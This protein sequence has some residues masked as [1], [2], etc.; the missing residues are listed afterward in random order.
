M[1]KKMTQKPNKKQP[2]P[3]DDVLKQDE[4]LLRELVSAFIKYPDR[5]R[6]ESERRSKDSTMIT[7]QADANDYGKIH[8]RQGR[9]IQALST[10]FLFIAGRGGRRVSIMNNPPDRG[11]REELPPFVPNPDWE[12]D[13]AISLLRK[14]L[15]R[16]LRRPYKTEPHENDEQTVI[17]ITPQMEEQKIVNGIAPYLHP[18]FHAIG[19]NEGRELSIQ[20]E[21]ALPDL[22]AT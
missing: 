8:G 5:L 15:D 2:E 4:D 20:E 16:I 13:H 6:I 10:I 17:K 12:P 3:T 22:T 7:M 9:N 1:A 19:K 11:T 14:V 18:I 21:I